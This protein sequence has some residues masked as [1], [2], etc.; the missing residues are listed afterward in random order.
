MRPT[1]H[2]VPAAIGQRLAS[3]GSG[4]A[5]GTLK[6]RVTGRSGSNGIDGGQPVIAIAVEIAVVIIE[7]RRRVVA[8]ELGRGGLDLSL[9]HTGEKLGPLGKGRDLQPARPGPLP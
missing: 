3:A 7:C 2:L 1:D 6:A 8:H 9:E 4:K 5:N